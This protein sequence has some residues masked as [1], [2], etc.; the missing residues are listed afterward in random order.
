MTWLDVLFAKG[1]EKKLELTDLGLISE[2]DK[3]EMLYQKFSRFFAK[4]CS[5]PFAKRSLWHVLWQTVSYWKLFVAMVL[6]LV[7][8]AVQFGPVLILT[9]LVKH[10]AGVSPLNIVQLWILVVLL[11]V[12]PMIT[13]ITLA[14]SN[15]IMAHLGAQMR[16]TLVGVI[17]RK[18]LVISSFKRQSL[19]TGRIITM[20]SDDTNQIR[21]FLFFLNNSLGAPFQIAACLYL[22]YQQVGAATFVGLGYTVIITP[23]SGFVFNIVAKL[24][25]EKMQFTDMR[26]KLMN[27]VLN[28]IRIIK[29]YSWESAFVNKITA[30]R[31]DE[32]T[33]LQKMGY[34]F[35]T[36][37][38]FIML[39]APQVQTVLIFFTYIA[40]NHTLDAATAFTTLTLFG[41]M[42]SPFIFLPFGIQQLSQSLISTGRIMEFLCADEVE[43]Y[44]Q[45]LPAGGET[46][47]EFETANLAWIPKNAAEEATASTP[48]TEAAIVPEATDKDNE[49]AVSADRSNHTL[50][51]VNIKIQRGQLVGIVGTVGSGKSSILSAI[52]GEMHLRTGAVRVDPSASVAYCDQR[53]WI[54]NANV[55]EN[56]L[57]GKPFDEDRFQAAISAAAMG[58]DIKI[59]P[60][61]VL[62]EI[63][64][65]GI[66]LSGGQKARVSLA[67]AVYNDADIYLLDDPLSAV[68]A[69]VGEHIFTKCIK[70]ALHGKTRLLVTHHINILPKCDVVI[71]LDEHGSVRATGTFEDICNSGIDVTKYLK[72]KEEEIENTVVDA[73]ELGPQAG[74]DESSPRSRA[75]SAA[76]FEVV[77]AVTEK[78]DVP[79]AE[80]K[81]AESGRVLI[82]KEEM[83]EGSV[84]W[85]TYECYIVY[86]G[87]FAFA[88]TVLFQLFSQVLQIEA[89]FWLVDWGKATTV[90]QY[91]PPYKPMSYYESLSWLHG[92]AGM[93]IASVFVMASSRVALTYHRTNA[94]RSLHARMLQNILFLPVSFFDVTPIGRIVN[95]FSQDV[96]TVDEDLAQAMSQLIGMGGGCLGSVGAITGSTKGTFLILVIPLAFL[97]MQIQEYFRRSNTAIAR[98]EAVS[99]SPI[100]ADF[101]QTLGGTSTIRAYHLQDQFINQLIKYA[102]SNTVP[103]LLQQ[104]SSQW[105]SIRLDFLGAVIMFFMGVLTLTSENSKFIPAGYLALGLS[106][107]IQ[108]TSLLKMTVR[109]SS[110]L[111]AQ[112][113]A[114]DRMRYYVDN[115]AAEGLIVDGKAMDGSAARVLSAAPA[116]DNLEMVVVHPNDPPPSDKITAYLVPDPS[117]PHAGVVQFENVSLSYRDG[118]LVLK[119]VSF[120]INAQE[121]VGIAGRTGCGKS[122]LMVALFRIEALRTGRIIIDGIDISKISLPS[123]RSKL[124]IIPQ[125][126][127]M[128]SATVRFN[129]DPFDDFKTEEI[130]EVLKSV[131][132]YEHVT[133]LKNGL[134]EMVS[135]GGDNFSAGQRQLIC[136]ARAIL[137]KP[138]VLVMDEATASIDSETDL[139][140][141]KMIRE[142]FQ[143]CTVLTI[144]HR[145]H[146]II[147]ST[148]VMVMDAGHL[149]ECAPPAELLVKERGLFKALWEKH[150]AEGGEK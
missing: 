54:I 128:F 49:A 78:K 11:F 127:V 94:S 10:F 112:F 150:V 41:L 63:G 36:V 3:S 82:T 115:M 59:L 90:D 76:E 14:H 65:R 145:L 2:Q 13:S 137:R 22:I 140:I 102:D 87:V 62:T 88:I 95:R 75:P 89:N 148:K 93:Q 122:S 113:N 40:T 147:D 4:E 68:D 44:V 118:P 43:P 99:R 132:M 34:L 83:G 50:Q 30:I 57:F 18:S 31:K 104:M 37:F 24:R 39:G 109:V 12:F 100:Y 72:K 56:I 86:G 8:A 28:G 125:D 96:A 69:H 143:N 32:M 136:I 70:E 58:D 119:N 38:G 139:F 91:T 42:T 146:T 108:L 85:K 117:W 92:Y 141:Q 61:G 98:L 55:R 60:A 101:S 17:Y 144:A 134:Q 52:L 103:G 48:A 130:E 53:P 1:Y 71:I 74:E 135:E 138:R 121:K 29:Y 131:N 81:K 80:E 123:L 15:A 111:E 35:N 129:L 77:E 26:V 64:E 124:C 47:I 45:E 46:A 120:T 51:D 133:G 84:S 16:N 25:R 19:T 6:F 66:N 67:R 142:K 149:A 116:D 79:A 114:V 21:Q 126:P 27:E 110:T 9:R 7:S 97:Y 5:K 73:S 33:Y 107:A 23:I 20:F 106:Y 105:L